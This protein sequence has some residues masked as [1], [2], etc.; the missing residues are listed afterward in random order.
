MADSPP[1]P[2]ASMQNS[3]PRFPGEKEMAEAF[4]SG[5][6]LDPRSSVMKAKM[7]TKSSTFS[8]A[9]SIRQLAYDWKEGL[10][11]IMGFGHYDYKWLCTPTLPLPGKVRKAPMFL[12]LYE[13]L[14]I[15]LAAMMGFQHC[16]AMLGGIITPPS[17]IA[18]DGCFPWQYDG[19]LCAAKQYLISGSLMTSGILTTIQVTRSKIYKTNFFIGTG[20]ISVTGTSF[21]FLPIAREYIVGEIRAGRSGYEAYGECPG[22]RPPPGGDRARGGRLTGRDGLPPSPRARPQAPSSAR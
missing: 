14:P 1:S 11:C 19:D 18:S 6:S 3:R 9:E 21:T 20:L 4:A 2:Q 15:V 10:G 12:G 8:L 13:K 7:S 17:L 5:A 22:G 16:L